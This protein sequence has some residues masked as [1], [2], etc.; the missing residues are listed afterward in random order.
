M[1]AE[2]IVSVE[3]FPVPERLQP[4]LTRLYSVTIDCEEGVVFTDFLHPEWAALR[5]VEGTPI[6][7]SVGPG[8][9]QAQ[10]PFIAHGPISKA[11]HFGVSRSRVW[12]LSLQPAGWAKFI[13][14]PA[15]EFSD[16]TFDG[17]E[18]RAFSAFDPL[19]GIIRNARGNSHVIVE[20]M[21]DHLNRLEDRD[22]SHEAQIFACQEALR[23]PEIS[24]VAELGERIGMSK[25]SL[26]RL[27]RRYFGFPPKVLLRR[28]RFLRSLAQYI[29]APSGTWIG[30]MDGQYH[31]QAQFVREF[32][33][34]MGLSP[35][36]YASLPHPILDALVKQGR[37]GGIPEAP[38]LDLPTVM[39]YGAGGDGNPIAGD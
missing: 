6:L 37:A 38:Q 21:L 12:G 15:D 39:R 10:S 20:Q 4:Y 7:A 32:R 13:D 36:Q 26:G 23:D 1:Q 8:L 24:G 27:C 28:Q 11:I 5:F 31:D 14:G 25:R 33:A 29:M 22:V 16:R 35:R 2:N 18:H 3:N 9:L 19:V 34:F 30:A 17:S